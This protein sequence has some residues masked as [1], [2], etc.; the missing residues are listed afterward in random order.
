MSICLEFSTIITHST[1]GKS[2]G[3]IQTHKHSNSQTFKLTKIFKSFH[4]LV[5]KSFKG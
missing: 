4:S 5:R 2:D 1:P 3:D